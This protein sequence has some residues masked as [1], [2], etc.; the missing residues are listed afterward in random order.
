MIYPEKKGQ[1]IVKQLA[2]IIAF[3]FWAGCAHNMAINSNFVVSNPDQFKSEKLSG[4]KACLVL[5]PELKN[6]IFEKKAYNWAGGSMFKDTLYFD[7]GKTVSSEIDNLVSA[8]FGET[9][10]V[11]DMKDA[12]GKNAVIIMP[13]IV[14]S[15]LDLPA[16]RGGKIKAE[17]RLKYLFYDSDGKQIVSQ[18]IIG[19]GIKSLVMTKENY[20]VAFREAIK[21]LMNKSKDAIEKAVMQKDE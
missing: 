11:S 2:V 18:T 8:M 12:T 19:N 15:T 10:K 20:N 7:L 1:R 16:I 17:I 13:E 3:I 6:Y 14:D 9:C 21:D 5:P 4:K